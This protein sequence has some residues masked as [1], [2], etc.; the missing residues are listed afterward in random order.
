MYSSLWAQNTCISSLLSQFRTSFWH[1]AILHQQ[2][3]GL[4]EIHFWQN[5]VIQLEIQKSGYTIA[6]VVRNIASTSEAIWEKYTFCEIYKYGLKIQEIQN[7]GSIIANG[8]SRGVRGYRTLCGKGHQ[9]LRNI[10]LTSDTIWGKYTFSKY[11]STVWKYE[12]YK[13]GVHHRE[14]HVQMFSWVQDIFA[15]ISLIAEK[16]MQDFIGI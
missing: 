16:A 8:V 7:W 12:K 14:R 6:N 13:N 5:I 11:R 9:T 15:D 1:L 2:W 10:A 4:G 3:R